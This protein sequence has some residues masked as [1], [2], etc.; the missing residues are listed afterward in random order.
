MTYYEKHREQKIAY[1]KKWRKENWDQWYVTHR[2]RCLE[3][4]SIHRTAA[5][6]FREKHKEKRRNEARIYNRKYRVLNKA[7]YAA[8]EMA[9]QALKLMAM[10]PW[11][12]REDILKFY[13][14]ARRR[15]LIEGV[16][17]HVDHI[18]PLRGKGFVGLHVPWNL[19]VIPA[20]LNISKGNRT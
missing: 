15:S 20:K 16:P 17:Y 6:R 4:P 5:A 7:R 18:F 12:Q 3:N 19:Q 8:H 11:V 2:K 10:P 9:R 13:V 1:A 14:E